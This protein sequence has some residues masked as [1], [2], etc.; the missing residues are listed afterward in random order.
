MRKALFAALAALALAQA[1]TAGVD[2]LSRLFVPGKAV[3]DL[4]G[5]GFPEKPAVTIII[6]DKPSSVESALAADIA[7]RT[8]FESL[9]V[10]FG[11]VRRESEVAGT[12]AVPFPILIGNGLAWTR[13]AAKERGLDLGSL[14]PN[15]GRVFLVPRQGFSGI[16]CVAGSDEALLKTGRAF[17]LRWP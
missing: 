12:P 5:D 14:R 13:Q 16:A 1:G 10:A 15:E 2:S 7:A 9:A 8:N 17:F 6:P 3:L 11:L 4:D